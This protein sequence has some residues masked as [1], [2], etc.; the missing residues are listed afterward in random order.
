MSIAKPVILVLFSGGETP[1]MNSLLRALVRLGTNRHDATILG[2]RDGFQGLVRVA[3]GIA[4]G[5][6][7]LDSLRDEIATH[8]GQ[9][10]LLRSNQEII[11]LDQ[12]SVCGLAGKGGIVLGAGRSPEFLDG[13][14]RRQVIELLRELEV[15]SIIVCGGNGSL[16]G[17]A[18]LAAESKLQVLGIPVTIDNDVSATDLALGVDTAVNTIMEVVEKLSDAAGTHHQIMVLEVMGRASGELARLAGLA[19]GAEIVVTPERGPL[20]AEKMERIAARL[21]R[22]MIFGRRHG[23]V[24]LSEGVPAEGNSNER[25]TMLLTQALERYFQRPDVPLPTTEIRAS[26]L[27]HLQRGGSPSAADRILAARFADATWRAITEQFGSS[28]ML[29]LKYNRI[30]LLPFPAANRPA[31]QVNRFFENQDLYEISKGLSQLA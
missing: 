14:V 15:S 2:I 11:R 26:V 13:T 17:A 27:G 1:G 25:A 21:E 6:R 5:K 12:K 23:I 4:L 24:L 10:G 7:T 3:L 9:D 31:S 18:C 30:A 20:T 22:A 28:Y 19:A 8:P 16:A 29:G